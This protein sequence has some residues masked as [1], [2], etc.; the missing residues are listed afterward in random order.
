MVEST[1]IATNL[2]SFNTPV[3]IIIVLLDFE[4]LELT[5]KLN[6]YSHIINPQRSSIHHDMVA[7]PFLYTLGVAMFSAL[8]IF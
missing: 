4:L 2:R 5:T 6:A 7:T 1:E 3:C 8:V